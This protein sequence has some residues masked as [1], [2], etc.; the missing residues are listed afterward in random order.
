MGFL[1]GAGGFRL[2]HGLYP[3]RLHLGGF[4]GFGL[5]LF[6]VP[7]L[8]RQ[9]P[10]PW[11]ARQQA[12][13]LR[14]PVK[15]PLESAH[16]GDVSRVLRALDLALGLRCGGGLTPHMHRVEGL[17]QQRYGIEV[18]MPDRGFVLVLDD[19]SQAVAVSLNQPANDAPLVAIPVVEILGHRHHA[20]EQTRAILA[21][22]MPPAVRRLN[23]P[24]VRGVFDFI[25]RYAIEQRRR[26]GLLDVRTGARVAARFGQNRVDVVPASLAFLR[27]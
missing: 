8:A 5:L 14:H 6:R 24:L 19:G 26:Y 22:F 25:E 11:P 27:G 4:D 23:R 7:L 20:R 18:E 21:Q 12:V 1:D 2:A 15:I 10:P 16:D 9:T 3:F 17:T 13:A